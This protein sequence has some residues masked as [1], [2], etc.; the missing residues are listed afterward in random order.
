MTDGEP[1]AIHTV[2]MHAAGEPVRLV[3]SGY[4]ELAGGTILDKRRDARERYDHLRRALMHEPRG[5]ADMYGVIPVAPTHPQAAFAALFMH[6]E[7]YSTMCGHATIALGRWLVETG[8]VPAVEPVTT[9]AVELPCG[10]VR[11]ACHVAAGRV[12]STRFESVPAFL[13]LRAVR[14]SVPGPAEVVVDVAYGGAF[15]AVLPASRLGL[16][17]FGTPLE[18]L[19]REAMAITR[20]G[21]ASLRLDH[22]DA[23]E[24]GFLYGTILTDDA[25]PPRPTTNLCVF[26][27]GQVDRSPT[28]SGATA[29]MARDAAYGLL[30]AGTPRRFHGPS[31]IPFE[32]EIVAADGAGSVVVAVTGTSATIGTARFLIDP[33]DPLQHGLVL[34]ETLPPIPS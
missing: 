29:R 1:L 5:H 19:R 33:G 9:F 20:A 6:H 24:L 13:A 7:G 23:D 21:R 3:V 16:D 15:Y 30:G 10:L 25:P 4:P 8:R 32:A 22:P 14:L 11:V 27:D 17:L 34:P 18:T 12:A 2:E 26:A 31:G 28:G